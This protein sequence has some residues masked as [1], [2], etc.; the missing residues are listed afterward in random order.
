VRN[1]RNT[2]FGIVQ[3]D[4]LEYLK[5]FEANDPEV[6]KAVKGVRIMFPLYN[7]EIHVLARKD[8]ASM[9]DLAGKKIAVGKKD[10]GTF[11]TATLIMDIL[12]VKA[13]AR[14]DINP[15]EAL[16]K[17]MSGEIDAFFYVAGAPAALFSGDAIDKTKF[18]LVPITEAPLLATP[19]RR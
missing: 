14:M 10:S 5:T 12:Q 6:Q 9:K 18:H 1:R 15:D 16:P 19:S 8:I 13:G 2:Q 3:S 11:L 17:L 4:V 7:E